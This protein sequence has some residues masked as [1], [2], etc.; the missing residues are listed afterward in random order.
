MLKKAVIYVRVSSKEQAEQGFSPE[1]QRVCLYDFARRND[2]DI[3]EEFEEAETAKDSGRKKFAEMVAYVKEYSIEFILVEKTDRLHRNFKDYVVVEEL[4]EKYGVTVHLVKEGSVV[5]KNSKASDKTMHGLRTVMAKGFIDNLREEVQKGFAIKIS[6]GGYPHQAPIGYLNAKDPL[7]PMHNIVIPDPLN[8]N[9]I[10][11]MF[12]YYSSGIYSMKTLIEKLDSEGLTQNLP[13]FIKSRKLIVTTV[14]RC[15]SNPFYIGRFQWSGKMIEGAHEPIVSA[16]LWNKVQDVL[17]GRNINTKKEHNVIP[18]MYKGIF[19]CGFCGRTVTAEKAK[20]KYS[21][22][23]CTQ[24]KTDCKQP[25]VKEETLDERFEKLTQLLRLSDAGLAFVTAGLKKSLTKKREGADRVYNT[26]V[27]EQERLR[28]R[29]DAMYEDRLDR[30]I[31]EY[32]YDRRFADY[33]IQLQKLDARI[34]QHNRT[35]IDYYEFGCRILELAEN[36]EKLVKE[37]K[38]EE[39]RELMQFLLSNSKLLDGEPIFSL[40]LPFSSI[41]KRSPCDDRSSWQGRPESNRQQGFWRPV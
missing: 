28:K 2:F 24:Y 17:N 41:E 38:P 9:L 23:H 5:G 16:E 27:V 19:T 40:R 12:E 6:R 3:V 20:G 11:K 39:K 29:M 26:L 13:R 33:T 22:Y 36:A 35:D 34:A 31:S 18:F 32:D 14:A 1:A 10:V 21:Y 7:N 30:R 37:A 25:W 15:L 4:T 8:R